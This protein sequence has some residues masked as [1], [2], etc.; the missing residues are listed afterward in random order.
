MQFQRW[1]RISI[2]VKIEIELLQHVAMQNGMLDHC[3]DIG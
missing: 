3:V 2:Y 1:I